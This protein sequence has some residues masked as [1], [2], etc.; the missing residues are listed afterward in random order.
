VP[1]LVGWLPVVPDLTRRFSVMPDLARRLTTD[2]TTSKRATSNR[3]G[4]DWLSPA[5]AVGDNWGDRTPD[6]ERAEPLLDLDITRGVGHF[7][8]ELARLGVL[9]VIADRAVV[10]R[11]ALSRLPPASAPPGHS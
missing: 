6:P 3:L 2:R 1:D 11:L 10:P 9:T 5:V 8:A 4:P 7:V